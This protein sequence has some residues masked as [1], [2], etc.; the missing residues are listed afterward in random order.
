LPSRRSALP[1]RSPLPMP[2]CSAQP[3][4]EE[5]LDSPAACRPLEQPAD[6]LSLDDEQRR[7]DLHPEPLREVW[8][9]LDRHPDE[10]ERLVVAAPLE[11]L[12]DEALG[13]AAPSREWR[14]EEDEVRSFDRGCHLPDR[15]PRH[16]R[17]FSGRPSIETAAG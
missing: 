15:H 10:V 8:P 4:P 12:R 1:L 11:Y 13:P 16:D 14:V 2:L 17:I 6:A 9:L 3:G 5:F 7:Q